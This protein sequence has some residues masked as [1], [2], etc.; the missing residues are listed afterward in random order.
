MPNRCGGRR[1]QSDDL[2][3]E[4]YRQMFRL[5]AGRPGAA[6]QLAV[7]LLRAWMPLD[8]SPRAASGRVWLRK[9][10]PICI[11]LLEASGD[12]PQATRD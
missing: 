9:I 6:S 1:N 4:V 11:G 10:C 2:K 7:A 3:D 8:A 5:E 12:P